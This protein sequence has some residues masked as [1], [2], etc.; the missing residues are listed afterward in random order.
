M[1]WLLWLA[2]AVVGGVPTVA[3]EVVV[4]AIVVV[5]G[6][7]CVVGAGVMG[8]VAVVAANRRDACYCSV[9][10]LLLAV[11]LLSL[12]L[13]LLVRLRAHALCGRCVSRR[14]CRRFVPSRRITVCFCR[15]WAGAAAGPGGALGLHARRFGDGRPHEAGRSSCA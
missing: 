2:I 8:V 7:L 10:L 4:V 6:V 11:W 12:V 1:L 13:A 5:G 9:A 14:L 3:D 15:L